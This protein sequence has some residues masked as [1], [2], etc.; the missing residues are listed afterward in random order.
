MTDRLLPL[1][2]EAWDGD[3]Q[4]LAEVYAESIQVCGILGQVQGRAHLAQFLQSCLKAFPNPQISLHKAFA[5]A[6]G[7]PHGPASPHCLA[8]SQCRLWSGPNEPAWCLV[9]DFHAT[10]RRVSQLENGVSASGH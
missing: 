2:R 9:A 1:F 7:S 3:Q 5:D 6:S 10:Q 8:E 4:A